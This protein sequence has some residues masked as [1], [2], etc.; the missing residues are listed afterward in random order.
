MERQARGQET[1]ET[2]VLGWVGENW[3]E[4]EFEKY[5]GIGCPLRWDMRVSERKER[6]RT[7]E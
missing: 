4:G 7:L 2:F 5:S 1:A 3:V 6:K